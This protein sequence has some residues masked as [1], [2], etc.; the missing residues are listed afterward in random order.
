MI[1]SC[2]NNNRAFRGRARIAGECVPAL[3]R[4]S[5]TQLNALPRGSKSRVALSLHEELSTPPA[6][7]FRLTA[8]AA[9]R[10]CQWMAALLGPVPAKTLG[11]LIYMF[12]SKPH[13]SA[14][15]L[16]SAV[17]APCISGST[18]R[19][20]QS[21]RDCVAEKQRKMRALSHLL[22]GLYREMRGVVAF[23]R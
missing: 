15:I 5:R 11:R 6:G 21:S 12:Q 14:A 9:W 13:Q 16:S 7:I 10:G 20:Q 22:H 8:M 17:N 1:S 19:V 2:L 18:R 4:N 23:R 3:N